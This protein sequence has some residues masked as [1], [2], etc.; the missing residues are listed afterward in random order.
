[1]KSIILTACAACLLYPCESTA[2]R[3]RYLLGDSIASTAGWV[4]EAGGTDVDT[5]YDSAQ[6]ALI[7]NN[8]NRNN[9]GLLKL[10]SIPHRAN[11]GVGAIPGNDTIQ[12]DSLVSGINYSSALVDDFTFAA[13]VSIP[14][15][16]YS[17]LGLG[18]C[19]GRHQSGYYYV[20]DSYK[21]FTLFS[22]SDDTLDQSGRIVAFNPHSAIAVGENLLRVTKIASTIR[23]YCN[24][25]LIASVVDTQFSR[26]KVGLIAPSA[27]VSTYADIKLTA[28][29]TDDTARTRAVCFFDSFAD[30]QSSTVTGWSNVFT[31]SEVNY[32]ID[33]GFLH[34][35]KAATDTLSPSLLF[36][37]GNLG[38]Y[39]VKTAMQWHDSVPAA[40]FFGI[41]YVG[42]VQDTASFAYSYSDLSFLISPTGMIA[43]KL[44]HGIAGEDT[45]FLDSAHHS[46]LHVLDSSAGF[47]TLVT[48]AR[49][50]SLC[51]YINDSLVAAIARPADFT[52]NGAGI[53]S[54]ANLA[55]RVS[56]FTV[57]EGENFVCGVSRPIASYP[58]G[59]RFRVGAVVPAEVYDLRGRR[60]IST[61]TALTPLLLKLPMGLYFIR[62]NNGNMRVIKRT[63]T[64]IE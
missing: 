11:I 36:T 30:N 40:S 7:V 46:I 54:D 18:F 2:S 1:M 26:G 10:D 35:E 5:S 49:N 43:I 55:L 63:Q 6:N 31:Q 42:I 56:E 22:F 51:F 45:L 38:G 20:I 17:F 19:M 57:G 16:F 15:D 23:L 29:Q 61:H 37:S 34:I 64:G 53:L 32:R 48:Q 8:T 41:A 50:D 28:V 62:T 44:N 47:D 3:T 9:I 58:A 14:S 39:S 24:D 4:I 27:D 21:Q 52:V 33:T 60:L 13:K 25:Y 12:E 59:R